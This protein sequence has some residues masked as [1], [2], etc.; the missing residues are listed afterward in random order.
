M[1]STSRAVSMAM[2]F[3]IGVLFASVAHGAPPY[4]QA[5]QV[6]ATGFENGQPAAV[7]APSAVEGEDTSA[8]WGRSTSVFRSG[9]TGLWCAGSDAAGGP[10]SFWPTYP[11]RT[12]GAANLEVPELADYFSSTLSFWYVM[13]SRGSGDS[14]TLAVG[15]LG[16]STEP[17][18]V[19]GEDLAEVA[20]WT[21]RVFSFGS[22]GG[23]MAASRQPLIVNFAFF[24]DVESAPAGERGQGP[25]IDDIAIVA[26]KYGPVRNLAATWSDGVG[27]TLSWQPPAESAVSAEDD[28]RPMAYRVWRSLRGADQ[29]AELTMGAPVSDTSM[30]DAAAE[31][32]LIYD[33]VVQA[34]DVDGVS[35]H[36]VQS[37]PVSVAT[38]GAPEPPIAGADSYEVDY[39]GILNVPAPGVLSNDSSQGDMSVVVAEHPSHG[40]VT[41][42]ADGSFEY[43]PTAGWSG[44]DA[45]SYRAVTQ[46]V[47]SAPTTVTIL[48]RPKPEP[49]APAATTVVVT[50]VSKTLSKYGSPYYLTGRLESAGKPLSGRTVVLETARASSG[51]FSASGVSAV[52]AADGSYSLRHVPRSKTFYRVRFAG[53]AGAF[54]E[55]T[56][57][58]RAAT[59]RAYVRTPIAPRTMRAGRTST[60]Y[61]YLKPRHTA[62]TYPVRI[63]RYR[64]VGGKWKRYGYVKA[65]ASSYSSYTKYTAKVKLPYR[66]RWRLRAY[67]PADSAHAASWSGGFD[68]VTVR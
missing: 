60:V 44:I 50:S 22:G 20:A 18:F 27:V 63:Y 24:D 25:A 15:R 62:G 36:G 3:M 57:V 58:I 59:P 34:W 66:G 23:V 2:A 11:A 65:K 31:P 6:F 17:P 52:T 53:Q 54:L 43:A 37:L 40:T 55:A 56:S 41:M 68:Y 42:A 49:P 5:E 12:R 46:S 47:Y 13:P 48:V 9:L 38:P 7:V 39:G 28:P 32:E 51:P 8:Y 33:Y 29:W 67:H 64:Y 30:V 1:R 19:Q 10:G 16:A 61:G 45:F 26:Y 14:F 21:Q 4:S 35:R